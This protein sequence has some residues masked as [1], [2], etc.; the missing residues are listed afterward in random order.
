MIFNTSIET[1]KYFEKFFG[2]KFPFTKYDHIFCPEFNSGAMENAGA[3]TL[4][5][6]YLFRDKVTLEAISNL[7]VV[8]AHELSHM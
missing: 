5:D 6:F 1:M 4:N 2:T 3:I 8:V 7:A